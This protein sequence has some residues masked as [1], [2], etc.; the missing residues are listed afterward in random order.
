MEHPPTSSAIAD[1]AAD[2][3]SLRQRLDEAARLMSAYRV[4]AHALD[5]E[6]LNKV[7]NKGLAKIANTPF[8]SGLAPHEQ[9]ENYP[10]F[11]LPKAKKLL[12]EYGKPVKIKLSISSA[13]PLRRSTTGCA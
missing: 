6:T 2:I 1:P 12:A 8:G 4:K 9:V 10:K 11:D 5:R 13:P 7:L 3:A